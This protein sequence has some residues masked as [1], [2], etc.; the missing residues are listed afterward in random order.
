MALWLSNDGNYRSFLVVVEVFVDRDAEAKVLAQK[1]HL[2]V[3]STEYLGLLLVRTQF[4]ANLEYCFQK[5]GL[6]SIAQDFHS[7]Y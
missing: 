3:E 2:P 7:H 6:S 5:L 1:F 4:L